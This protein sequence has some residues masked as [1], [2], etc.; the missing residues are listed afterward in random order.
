MMA[1]QIRR[2][3]KYL[4]GVQAVTKHTETDGDGGN[5][6]SEEMRE[7]HRVYMLTLLLGVGMSAA[8]GTTI[9]AALHYSSKFAG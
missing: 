1:E 7:F 8:V 9:W 4:E 5:G 6:I 2:A 3:M